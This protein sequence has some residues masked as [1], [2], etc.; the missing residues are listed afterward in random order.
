M[1]VIMIFDN[2]RDFE[3]ESQSCD[4]CFVGKLKAMGGKRILQTLYFCI[5]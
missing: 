4:H 1:G 3:V 2:D 5:E